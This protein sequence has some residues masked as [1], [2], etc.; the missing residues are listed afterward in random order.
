MRLWDVRT[1][2]AIANVVSLKGNL[3][4][5]VAFEIEWG[6]ENIKSRRPALFAVHGN[7]LSVHHL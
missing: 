1:G 4:P 5:S 6:R 2:I 3:V 7:E